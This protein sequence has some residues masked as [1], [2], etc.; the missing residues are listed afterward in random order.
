MKKNPRLRLSAKYAPHA[1][2][3]DVIRRAFDIKSNQFLLPLG[4]RTPHVMFFPTNQK[5]AKIDVN[6]ALGRS[7]VESEG[8]KRTIVYFF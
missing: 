5:R 2:M 8:T 6:H 7:S 4:S 3:P 1:S